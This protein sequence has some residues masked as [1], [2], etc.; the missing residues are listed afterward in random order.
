MANRRDAYNS[1]MEDLKKRIKFHSSERLRRPAQDPVHGGEHEEPDGDEDAQGN[2]PPGPE[3]LDAS[4]FE[5]I[6]PM[7]GESDQKPPMDMDERDIGK[8]WKKDIEPQVS[9]RSCNADI[10]KDDRFCSKCGDRR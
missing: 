10:K 1:S 5:R 2:E 7:D 3:E 6:H 9:C 4:Q 8:K